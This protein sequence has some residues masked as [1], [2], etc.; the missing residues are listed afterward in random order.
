MRT[1]N[2]Y[3]R[4]ISNEVTKTKEKQKNIVAV[5][6]LFVVLKMYSDY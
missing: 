5:Q 6:T 1:I 4:G 2:N 3:L